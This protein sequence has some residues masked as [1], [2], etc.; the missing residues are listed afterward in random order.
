MEH[1]YNNIHGWFQSEP[2]YKRMIDGANNGACFVEVGVWKGRSAAFMAVEIINSG[3]NID[4]YLVDHFKGSQEHQSDG[5]II[6]N[7]LEEECRSNLAPVSHVVKYITKQSVDAAKDF[8][9]ES[10][11]FVYI[12]ASHE[13]E[14]V[15]D[16][17]RAWLPKVKTGGIIAGDDYSI[18]FMGVIRAVNE[19]LPMAKKEDVVWFYQ[20]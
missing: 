20:K 6:R 3:K 15:R 17:I 1:F 5:V 10:I 2:L 11:D 8:K 16:D 4:L 13:Y 18:G 12:D 19:L 14:D 7:K 9:D